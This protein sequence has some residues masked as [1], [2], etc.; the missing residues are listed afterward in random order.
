MF[1]CPF[2]LRLA[3]LL[4]QRLG[5]HLLS[6]LLPPVLRSDEDS[7]DEKTCITLAVQALL[8]VSQPFLIP[9]P[10]FRRVRAYGVVSESFATQLRGENGHE[11]PARILLPIAVSDRLL[12][13]IFLSDLICLFCSVFLAGQSRFL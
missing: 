1:C 6:S 8:E 12:A 4:I 3:P 7:L 9:L 10:Y 5:S 2:F 13:E 11:L